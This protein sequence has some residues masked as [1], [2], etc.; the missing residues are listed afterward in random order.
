MFRFNG[1]CYIT[2]LNISNYCKTKYFQ[3]LQLGLFPSNREGRGRGRRRNRTPVPGV[4]ETP[5]PVVVDLVRVPKTHLEDLVEEE[6]EDGEDDEEAEERS[7]HDHSDQVEARPAALPNLS[8]SLA[9]PVQSEEERSDRQ[10]AGA[11]N[12]CCTWTCDVQIQI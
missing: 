9:P 1:A 5:V 6:G 11:D 3:G 7:F 2:L 4:M 12:R 8:P 10:A